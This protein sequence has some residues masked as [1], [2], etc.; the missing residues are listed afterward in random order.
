MSHKASKILATILAA[1]LFAMAPMHT[2]NAQGILQTCASDIMKFCSS[3]TPGDGRVASCLY[4]HEDQIAD[5]C[6]DAIVDIGDVLDYYHG[7][8]ELAVETCADDIGQ[9]CAATEFGEGRILSCLND[10]ASEISNGC[11]SVLKV[12]NEALSE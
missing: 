6:A 7:L 10:K 9:Y 11:S 4:A 3:V 5:Q 2:S 8:V 12:F 1:I